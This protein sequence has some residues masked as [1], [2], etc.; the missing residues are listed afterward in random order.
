MSCGCTDGLCAVDTGLWALPA[1]YGTVSQHRYCT[2]SYY[3]THCDLHI[4]SLHL[5]YALIAVA[6]TLVLY[7][8]S[9]RNYSAFSLPYICISSIVRYRPSRNDS[10]T[11]LRVVALWLRILWLIS[12][13]LGLFR[14]FL[15][16]YRGNDSRSH[17][18]RCF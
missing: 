18:R 16:V 1:L 8:I 9:Q 4:D 7:F 10:L 5:F 14:G 13:M 12:V 17:E 11:G 3:F 2:A 15:M 6:L